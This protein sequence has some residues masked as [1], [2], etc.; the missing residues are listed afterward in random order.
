MELPADR[1]D[2]DLLLDL[3]DLLPAPYL[4][5]NGDFWTAASNARWMDNDPAYIVGK[6]AWYIH[7]LSTDEASAGD[8]RDLASYCLMFFDGEQPAMWSV[9]D[10]EVG[11]SG[12]EGAAGRRL[13]DAICAVAWRIYVPAEAEQ[14]RVREPTRRHVHTIWALE[15]FSD[16]PSPDA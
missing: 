8:A 1:S 11:Y 10:Q 6:L 15:T 2:I 9:L 4:K 16:S 7:R 12:V 3:L 5:T 14:R 13:A